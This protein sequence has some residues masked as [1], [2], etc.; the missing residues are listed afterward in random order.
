MT[1][2]NND[3]KDDEINDYPEVNYGE[4]GIYLNDYRH[5]KTLTEKLL[6]NNKNYKNNE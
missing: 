5:N 4:W 1:C 3:I 6:N 2:S